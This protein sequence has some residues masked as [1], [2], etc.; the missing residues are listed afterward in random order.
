MNITAKPDQ[1]KHIQLTSIEH[2]L[3]KGKQHLVS[4]VSEVM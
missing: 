2:I 4:S 1:P 3:V